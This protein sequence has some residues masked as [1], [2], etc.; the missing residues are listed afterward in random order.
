MPATQEDLS[1]SLDVLA[2]VAIITVPFMKVPMAMPSLSA[3][4]QSIWGVLTTPLTPL[5]PKSLGAF[6]SAAM[7]SIDQ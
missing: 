6:S 1:I 4:L 5:V 3:N 7:D 2:S